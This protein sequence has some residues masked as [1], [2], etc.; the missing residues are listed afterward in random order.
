M[1]LHEYEAKVLLA[2]VSHTDY[3]D[4]VKHS[5][6]QEIQAKR[7]VQWLTNRNLINVEKKEY[8]IY[9]LT[10]Q[11]KAYAHKGTPDLRLLHAL[12]KEKTVTREK[13]LTQT[14]ITL[15]ELGA[16]LGR[17]KKL[18]AITVEQTA[19]GITITKGPGYQQAVDLEKNI[20]QALQQITTPVHSPDP[21][22]LENLR[23]LEQ[24]RGT[25]EVTTK[26]K[27]TITIT[28]QGKAI[29]KTTTAG[30]AKTGRLTKEMIVSGT[31]KNASFRAF[32]LNDPVPNIN[33]GRKHF[34]TQAI[35]YIKSIWLE[36][37]FSEMDG[38]YIQSAFWD[39]DVLFVP[40]D[41]P[42]RAMQDTFYM[43]QTT[44]LDKDKKILA[45]I[46]DIHENGGKT[47]SLGWRAPYSIQEAQ[48]LLL[49]T[50]CTALSAKTLQTIDTSKLPAKYFAVGKV[51]RNEAVDWSH[52]AEFHQVEGIVID[53]NA[54]FSNLLAYLKEFFG[55]MGYPDVRI[56]PAYFPYTEPS[57]EIEVFN[58]KRDKWVELGGCG[59]FRPEVVVP[60][61][62]EDI[63]VL[64]WGIGMERIIV[65][66]FGF[67]DLRDLYRNDLEQLQNIKQ[68][69]RM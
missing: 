52:L 10:E 16:T 15:Q 45:A 22:L 13:I 34:V 62:G 63:P 24:R 68:F 18:N 7:G 64:A 23:T 3:D 66:E 32:G 4:I 1:E 69:M 41:H 12:N 59:I 50:H 21:M 14:D 27:N 19:T 55:K 36:L 26:T 9:T 25:L 29:A 31:Y 38:D 44:N 5:G 40:Q 47:G 11:G 54:N 60:L 53:R 49:R 30:E 33:G 46:K 39:M 56:R 6:L 51:F 42:A 67:Q 65:E 28:A 35:E 20:A 37:G 2:S 43:E 58:P 17:L 57:A 61:L 48:K 8:T